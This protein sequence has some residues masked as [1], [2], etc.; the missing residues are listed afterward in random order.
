MFDTKRL[1]NNGLYYSRRERLE[2]F[3]FLKVAI[4]WVC[5]KII[6]GFYEGPD[7]VMNA[8]C[9]NGVLQGLKSRKNMKAWI[10]CP[11]KKK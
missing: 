9:I 2:M 8:W 6:E 4:L 11:K 1:R 7:I 10:L 3:Y 5:A